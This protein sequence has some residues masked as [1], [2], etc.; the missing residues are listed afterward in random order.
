MCCGERVWIRALHQT[1][2]E[3]RRCPPHFLRDHGDAPVRSV[4]LACA[5]VLRSQPAYVDRRHSACSTCHVRP[6]RA[7]PRRLACAARARRRRQRWVSCG[8]RCGLFRLSKGV[9]E[10]WDPPHARAGGRVAARLSRKHMAAASR[11]SHVQREC[12]AGSFLEDM[13][14]S[15]PAEY[16]QFLKNRATGWGS[17]PPQ[18][19]ARCID[20]FMSVC[21]RAIEVSAGGGG[22]SELTEKGAVA[23]FRGFQT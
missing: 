3:S 4:V 13:R 16:D 20:H 14:D 9:C 21:I 8:V 6:R 11:G 5:V 22:A 17:S 2:R 15:R 1:N 7:G 12:D 18:P 23:F 10:Q 19:M